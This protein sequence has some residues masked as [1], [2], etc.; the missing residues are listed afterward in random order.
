MRTRTLSI[1]GCWANRAV[2]RN[3]RDQR[4]SESPPL[5]TPQ[6]GAQ[7]NGSEDGGA[8]DRHPAIDGFVDIHAPYN[9]ADLAG[10]GQYVVEEVHDIARPFRAEQTLDSTALLQDGRNDHDGER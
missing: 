3:N 9:L 10:L 5:E 4:M 8:P 7:T 1:F 6:P 2:A